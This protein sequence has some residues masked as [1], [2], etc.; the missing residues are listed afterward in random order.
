[1]AA[2]LASGPLPTGRALGA[3]QEESGPFPKAGLFT[4]QASDQTGQVGTADDPAIW[5]HPADPA[6]SLVIGT[7]KDTAGGLHVFDLA[8]NQLQFVAGG[9]HNNVDL[10]YGFGLGGETVDLVSACDRNDNRIDVYKVDPVG[11]RLIPV[12]S[13]QAGIEVYGYAMYHSRE[14]GKLYGIVAS[15]DGVEQWELVDQG[16]SVGGVLARTLASDNLIEGVVADDEL[17][18]LYVAEEDHGIYKYYAEPDRPDARLSTVDVV[19]SAT[20]LTADVEG[21]TI[22]YRGGGLGYLIASSQGNDRFVVYR[23]EGS[24]A[25]LGTFEVGSAEDTDGIDVVN[26]A[27]GPSFPLGMFVAQNND[28]DFQMVPWERIAGALGLAIDTQG[29]EVRGGGCQGVATVEVVP[30]EAT[31]E[32]GATLQLTATPE[33]ASGAALVGCA[34]TWSTSDPGVAT[35]SSGGLVAGVSAG[36]STITATS[37]DVSGSSLLTVAPS[38]NSDPEVTVSAIPDGTE[39]SSVGLLAS[40]SDADAAD[41]HTAAIDWGDGSGPQAGT[42]DEAGRTVTGAHVYANDG[43]FPVRVTVSDNRGGLGQDETTVTVVNVP[44]TA[45]AGG[46]YSGSSGQ[47]VG[48]SG[49]ASD[50][51]ADPLVF[52]WDFDYAATFDVDATGPAVQHAYPPGSYVV[53]LRVWDD[54]VASAVATATVSVTEQPPVVLYLAL[55]GSATLGGVGVANEDIVAFDGSGFRLH[56]DG[57]DVG[58]AGAA[59]DAFAVLSPTEILLS[60]T[61]ALSLPGVAGTV[62]DSDIVRFTATS[63]GGQTAGSFALYFDASDVGLSTGDEDVDACEVLADGR[64]L[65]STTG[66]SSV[67]GVSGQDEDLLL[68]T[69]TSLGPATAGTWS[70]Y[71]DGSD[72][73]LSSS[74]EDVDAAAIDGTG[75]L[76][77]STTGAFAVTGR[78]GADE[79]VFVFTPSSTGPSTAGSFSPTLRFD[80]SLYGLGSNDVVAVDVP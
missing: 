30:A 21:L 26:M 51:G 32:E 17:G 19:G 49:T 10:R 50:P 39:G 5:V 42:L 3:E 36:L 20:Q 64:L 11:R 77:L 60:F 78:S 46:P 59:V 45:S 23:R 75:R 74:D 13:I 69:P 72:V 70:L 16:G 65:V 33:D 7:N 61:D 9:R 8:G 58:L 63:L 18:F 1:M 71:F 2:V 52:E 66:A 68:F 44:P 27:L 37:L 4:V 24:N 28:R 48:F 25:H 41:V 55:S 38:T 57:S 53:A 35:V 12:G 80:G 34:V 14:T 76:C 15:G 47:A 29:Y 79:D 31:L 54:D 43:R 56:F 73:G 62:D 22:Y 40:F 6:Q 67:P